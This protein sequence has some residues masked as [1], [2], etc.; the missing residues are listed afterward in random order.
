MDE[1]WRTYDRLAVSNSV[2]YRAG[3][4][5]E[6]Y[7][8]RGF[9]AV[10]LA[11]AALLAEWFGDLRFLAFDGRLIN[12]ARQASL[13]DYGDRTNEGRETDSDPERG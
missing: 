8:L 5:A 4:M 7:A 13:I 9:D 12:A 6:L 11:S 2:A 3:E 10:H 1:E